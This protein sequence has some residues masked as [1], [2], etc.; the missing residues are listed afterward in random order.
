MVDQVYV[1]IVSL[2]GRNFHRLEV[3]SRYRDPQ[4][5]VEIRVHCIAAIQ[6]KNKVDSAIEHG[7]CV[8]SENRLNGNYHHP[9]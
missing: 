5:Q 3:V 7:I 8:L 1:V 6:P 4:L 2:S 9:W